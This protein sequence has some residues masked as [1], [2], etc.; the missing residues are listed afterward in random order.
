MPKRLTLLG[1]HT[2][3]NIDKLEAVQRRAARFV[4]GDFRSTSSVTQMPRGPPC[5]KSILSEIQIS[6]NPH[7]I[8]KNLEGSATQQNRVRDSE[9]LRIHR[10][11][12]DSEGFSRDS[13]RFP[14]TDSLRF[15]GIHPRFSGIHSRFSG[16]H[17]RFSVYSVRFTLDSVYIQ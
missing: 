13:L 15:G 14:G 11:F 8:Y 2:Q 10:R 3:C 7:A 5:F 12:R 1:P 9:S 17:P 4:I 6:W 16:I